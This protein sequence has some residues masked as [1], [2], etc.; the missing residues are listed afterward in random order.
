LAEASGPPAAR[1]LHASSV[2]AANE[3]DNR[4]DVR[5]E[6][7]ERGTVAPEAT[8]ALCFGSWRSERTLSASA[9]RK[10]GFRTRQ[11]FLLVLDVIE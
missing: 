5:K 4:K 10:S 6:E 2:A 8:G 1:Q 9:S 11:D 7:T 3:Q